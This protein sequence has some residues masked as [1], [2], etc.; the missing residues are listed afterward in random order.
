MIRIEKRNDL[1]APWAKGGYLMMKNR[2]KW[3]LAAGLTAA[4]LGSAFVISG[5]GAAT[6]TAIP[7]PETIQVQ[8]ADNSNI[9]TVTGTEEVKI[10]PDMARITYS[11]Y[12]REASA[13]ACQEANSQDL[14]RAIE[15]LKGLGVAETSIQTTAYG[16]QP[17][18]NWNSDKRE[19][20]GYEMTTSL[21]VSDIPVAQAGAIISQ[22]VEA[23]VNGIEAVDY[24]SSNY[25]EAYQEALQKAVASAREKAETIAQAGEKTL[26]GILHVEEQ[27]YNPSARY[28]N[29]DTL[30]SGAGAKLESASDIAVMPGQLSVKA[31]V[32]VDFGMNP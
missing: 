25:D 4:V 30:T 17:I 9:I 28:S 19:I 15:T 1:R 12:T 22:S 14:N 23:G 16:L 8:N 7:F 11:I 31:T 32:T 29:S 2:N 27:G 5:C 10:V 6:Q 3:T 26:S 18:Y 13:A 20:T 21:T 24:F